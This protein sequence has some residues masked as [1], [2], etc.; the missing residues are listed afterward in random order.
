MDKVNVAETPAL[1]DQHWQ[2]KIVSEMNDCKIRVV[3]VLGEFITLTP[4]Q[5]RPRCGCSSVRACA[6]P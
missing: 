4:A 6:R 1:F 3:N 5:E 2:P